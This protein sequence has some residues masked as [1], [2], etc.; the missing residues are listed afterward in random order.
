M[1]VSVPEP[2]SAHIPLRS[3]AFRWKAP[4][5]SVYVSTG[6]HMHVCVYVHVCA[7]YVHMFGGVRDEREPRVNGSVNNE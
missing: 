3:S 2:D 5:V 6:V 4:S 7:S 1:W